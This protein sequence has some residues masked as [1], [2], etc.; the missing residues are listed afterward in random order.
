MLHRAGENCSAGR[1]HHNEQHFKSTQSILI[2]ESL[3]SQK[4]LSIVRPAL[5]WSQ[6]N[7]WFCDVSC[8]VMKHPLKNVWLWSREVR[9]HTG[10]AAFF[11]HELWDHPLFNC[12][13]HQLSQHSALWTACWTCNEPKLQLKH[14][15]SHQPP[16]TKNKSPPPDMFRA[17]ETW[18]MRRSTFLSLFNCSIL[19]KETFCFTIYHRLFSRYFFSSEWNPTFNIFFPCGSTQGH[20]SHESDILL[21]VFQHCLELTTIEHTGRYRKGQQFAAAELFLLTLL[22]LLSV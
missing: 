11:F 5:I 2:S 20:V 14:Q 1:V 6:K 12:K 16:L 4:F 22:G 15:G 21:M 10:I 8:Y 13:G 17:A 18:R 9:W 3:Y 7:S 19:M